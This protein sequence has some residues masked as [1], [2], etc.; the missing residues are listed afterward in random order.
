VALGQAMGGL[1]A[2]CFSLVTIEVPDALS[3]IAGALFGV[4]VINISAVE[5]VGDAKLGGLAAGGSRR[6][7]SARA[8]TTP[9]ALASVMF[10]FV[11]VGHG[12]ANAADA[13]G[14]G[15][16]EAAPLFV[17]PARSR[18]VFGVHSVIPFADESDLAHEFA[19]EL[20]AAEFV[21]DL[22]TDKRDLAEDFDHD[23]YNHSSFDRLHQTPGGAD[24]SHGD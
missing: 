9:F 15:M 4:I 18:G 2:A 8:I 11:R 3:S 22:R 13:E 19:L 23:R 5:S 20:L 12:G 6:L 16:S 24:E 10:T 14:V 7:I 21:D 1:F 17:R